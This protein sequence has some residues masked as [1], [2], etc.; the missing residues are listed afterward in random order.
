M[1]K[2]VRDSVIYYICEFLQ[3]I[4]VRHMALFF[5]VCIGAFTRFVSFA[6]EGRSED[7]AYRNNQMKVR[8]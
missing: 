7:D 5:C 6:E 8:L 1:K 2:K 4:G 3:N